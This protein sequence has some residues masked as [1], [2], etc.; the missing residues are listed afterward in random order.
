MGRVGVLQRLHPGYSESGVGS[1]TGGGYGGFHTSSGHRAAE[2][3]EVAKAARAGVGAVGG[4]T[5][6]ATAAAQAAAATAS[7][8]EGDIDAVVR[9]PGDRYE[10]TLADTVRKVKLLSLASLAATVTC[11]P[12]LLELASPDMA[13]SST[14]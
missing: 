3:D 9:P 10:A 5:A 8:D 7:G 1:A 4:A 11:T 2:D 14:P 13:V 12:M 6:K